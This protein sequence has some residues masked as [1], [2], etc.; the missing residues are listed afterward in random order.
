M[1]SSDSQYLLFQFCLADFT[2]TQQCFQDPGLP[3]YDTVAGLMF[4]SV[5]KEFSSFIFNPQCLGVKDV[6]FLEM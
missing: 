5:V 2:F 6:H 4:P 1:D 3:V